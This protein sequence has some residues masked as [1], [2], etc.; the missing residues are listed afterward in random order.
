ML[1]LTQ[2]RG[3]FRAQVRI[4]FAAAS[5]LHAPEP[6]AIEPAERPDRG[7]ANERRRIVEKPLGFG[8][9]TRIAGIADRDQHITDKTRTADTLDRA[10]GEQSAER[11]I[12]EPGKFGKLRRAQHFARGEF[13]F[14]AGDRKFVPWTDREAIVAAIDAI[15]DQ[16]TQFAWDLPFVLD[17]EVGDAAPRIE[18]IRRGKRCRRA[19]IQASATLAAVI[20]FGLV[21]RQF[22]RGEDCAEKQPGAE[23]A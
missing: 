10:L 12:V 5:F 6:V 11:G 21:R 1:A 17:G 14:A 23:L 19:D 16:R 8:G 13:Y 9:E 18:T 7:T 2:C 20:A 22:K 3:P 4:G 15:A